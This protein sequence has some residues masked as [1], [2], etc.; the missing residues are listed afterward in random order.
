MLLMKKFKIKNNKV[1][2]RPINLILK[3]TSNLKILS[4]NIYIF[5]ETIGDIH[6]INLCLLII[7]SKYKL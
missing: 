2:N 7:F 5:T 4:K 1:W 3:D 6:L